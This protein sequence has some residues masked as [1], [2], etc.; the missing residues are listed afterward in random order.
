MEVLPIGLKVA[1]KFVG[2]LHRHH[3][4]PRGHKFSIGAQKSGILV[5]VAVV[6][7]PVARALDD[8]RTAEV[9]RLCTDGTRNACS[10]LYGATAR[11]AR[12]QGYLK[13]I[14]YILDSESGD[15]LIAAGWK[16]EGDA[17]GGSWSRGGR[18]REDKHPTQRKQRWSLILG[19]RK[20]RERFDSFDRIIG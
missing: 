18:P 11:A 17:G 14:T 4:E 7:R 2:T 3:G 15:S 16:C 12:E 8:G 20:A 1:A 13:I 10:F 5:G 19:G 6:G 9:T